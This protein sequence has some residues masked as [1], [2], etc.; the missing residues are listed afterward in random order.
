MAY[1][2][3]GTA[4]TNAVAIVQEYSRSLRGSGEFVEGDTVLFDN[5]FGNLRYTHDSLRE[6]AQNQV[7]TDPPPLESTIANDNS[8]VEERA[9]IEAVLS[10]QLLAA[11]SEHPSAEGLE[12]LFASQLYASYRG[13]DAREILR[14]ARAELLDGSQG[15]P[16]AKAASPMVLTP[17]GQ[18]AN[19]T[20][21]SANSVRKL[22]TFLRTVTTD[23]A[24]EGLFVELMRTAGAFPEQTN[25]TF[26]KLAAGSLKRSY[27]TTNDLGPLCARW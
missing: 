1:R 7:L 13:H 11:V 8:A 5:V 10:A 14:R 20:G 9:A 23:L 6:A 19:M 21:L 25:R 4:E 16:F 17:L 27:M 2:L 26:A 18:A 24:L 12:E 22:M 3:R 15:E